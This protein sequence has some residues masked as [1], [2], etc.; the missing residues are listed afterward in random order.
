MFNFFI[1]K[2]YIILY[3]FMDF[4]KKIIKTHFSECVKY[5][6]DI[7]EKEIN[8][9]YEVFN[10]ELERIVEFEKIGLKKIT[11][12]IDLSDE[13]NI[14]RLNVYLGIAPIG[15]KGGNLVSMT[16]FTNIS[17]NIKLMLIIGGS[18]SNSE[19][20]VMFEKIE[21]S[22][23][24]GSEQSNDVGS[25]QSN[26]EEEL[27]MPEENEYLN[28]RI[29][30]SLRFSR[31][32][33]HTFLSYLGDEHEL[34]KDFYE[35]IMFVCY[36][37]FS[38]DSI[39]NFYNNKLYKNEKNELVTHDTDD[40]I[41]ILLYNGPNG[42]NSLDEHIINEL[43]ISLI[44]TP[45]LQFI[46][47]E[48]LNLIKPSDLSHLN[49]HKLKKLEN[50]HLDET[51]KKIIEEEFHVIPRDILI[52]HDISTKILLSIYD[53]IIKIKKFIGSDIDKIV[54]ISGLAIYDGWGDIFYISTL[55]NILL[56]KQYKILLNIT[57]T[58][59]SND[60]AKQLV[61]GF[62][63]NNKYFTTQNIFCI[64]AMD[65][66][67]INN[68][69]KNDNTYVLNYV[70]KIIKEHKIPYFVYNSS[71]FDFTFNDENTQKYYYIDEFLPCKNRIKQG[72]GNHYRPNINNYF[73][74]AK[75][76]ATCKY[77]FPHVKINHIDVKQN[78]KKKYSFA[79]LSKNECINDDFIKK[80]LSR[81]NI[82]LM[83]FSFFER[84]NKDDLFTDYVIKPFTKKYDIEKICETINTSFDTKTKT[85]ILYDYLKPD[86]MNMFRSKSKNVYCTGNISLY[87]TL[88]L[89]KFPIY[90]CRSQLEY[91]YLELIKY[92]H[93][94]IILSNIAIKNTIRKKVSEEYN[95]ILPDDNILSGY[96]SYREF[97]DTF[98]LPNFININMIDEAIKE[99][100]LKKSELVTKLIL[101]Y[102]IKISFKNLTTRI[103][104]D[105]R[106]LKRDIKNFIAYIKSN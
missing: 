71:Y 49:V 41:N 89:N 92:I 55:I 48:L 73:G 12:N 59:A 67:G 66:F 17:D 102:K 15:A 13:T 40:I 26:D 21:Q 54:I 82:V 5:T 32:F 96:I 1:H 60:I 24:V 42:L 8:N 95:D 31:N 56:N 61:N 16:N 80:L 39:I 47:N 46:N 97:M 91:V 103:N 106:K 94:E 27:V 65:L 90:Q 99:T 4:K 45:S 30:N 76:T 53:D 44:N 35:R 19:N 83:N 101:E 81:E 20:D 18:L 68:R 10:D 70:K 52:D 6:M 37:I 98:F 2:Y 105:N 3:I 84:N 58:A 63:H 74:F 22:D 14:N 75:S 77:Y 50:F 34:V 69:A 7:I 43:F 86:D 33:H 51:N 88:C 38:L 62:I 64:G 72:K 57:G 28:F 29:I 100:S 93:E 23:D 104:Q 85:I 11:E 9:I 25:E 87:E 79:Y 36:Q 78:I